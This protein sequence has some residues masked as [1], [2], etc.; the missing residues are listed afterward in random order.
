MFN[1]TTPPDG[2]PSKTEGELA[3]AVAGSGGRDI[4]HSLVFLLFFNM[5]NLNKMLNKGFAIARPFLCVD[6]G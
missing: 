1:I 3:S 4:L 6:I 5:R 2:T